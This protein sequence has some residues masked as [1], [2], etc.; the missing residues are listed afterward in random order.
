MPCQ[1]KTCRQATKYVMNIVF[2]H[3]FC[4]VLWDAGLV[5]GGMKCDLFTVIDVARQIGVVP[6][7]QVRT[8]FYSSSPAHSS[9]VCW[10]AVK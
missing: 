5:G 4:Q 2:S 9:C 6:N 10:V 1:L 7:P 8:S 3:D